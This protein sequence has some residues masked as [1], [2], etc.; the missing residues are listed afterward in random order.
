MSHSGQDASLHHIFR[1]QTDVCCYIQGSLRNFCVV[2]EASCLSWWTP[3]AAVALG[4]R[5]GQRLRQDVCIQSHP[6][7]CP[8]QRDPQS[9]S[10]NQLEQIIHRLVLTTER[11]GGGLSFMCHVTICSHMANKEVMNT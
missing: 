6:S 2:F 1:Y 4:W 9:G 10:I 8:S 7:H 11:G 5:S 3:L